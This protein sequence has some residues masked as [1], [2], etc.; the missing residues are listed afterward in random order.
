MHSLD[1]ICAAHNHQILNSRQICAVQAGYTR[2]RSRLLI[3]GLGQYGSGGHTGCWAL[4]PFHRRVGRCLFDS[5]S[6]RLCDWDHHGSSPHSICISRSLSSETVAKAP[7]SLDPTPASTPGAFL[8]KSF[9][10]ILKVASPKSWTGPGSLT[11][12]PLLLAVGAPR[13]CR[14]PRSN[15]I[16]RHAGP[17]SHPISKSISVHILIGYLGCPQRRRG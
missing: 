4:V 10:S 7:S 16:Q 1:A 14:R 2:G 12:A 17:Q 8:D 3:S 15:V 13:Y 5:K 11:A 6:Y 9:W